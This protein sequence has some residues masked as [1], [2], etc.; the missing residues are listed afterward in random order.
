[1]IELLSD[2]LDD[3][4]LVLIEE[5]II[6]VSMKVIWHRLNIFLDREYDEDESNEI[7]YPDNRFYVCQVMNSTNFIIQSLRKL[8]PTRGELEVEC[9]GRSNLI[10]IFTSRQVISLS[11]MM[12]IDDFGIHRNMYCALKAFYW[13]PAN[14]PYKERRKLANIFTL[15]LGPHGADIED[16]VRSFVKLFKGLDHGCQMKLGDEIITVC[17]FTMAFLG[18]MPQQADNCG[19]L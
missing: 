16:V 12:F 3:H 2:D 9:Y 11:F 1:M 15:S 6:E 18:D 5:P 7:M 14:L 13:I 10:E 8:H 4:K 19:V 17:A